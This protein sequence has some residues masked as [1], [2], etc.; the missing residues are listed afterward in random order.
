MR[1]PGTALSSPSEAGRDVGSHGSGA[2][3]ENNLFQ[4]H[5]RPGG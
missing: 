3:P 5:V 1:S 4:M 2:N